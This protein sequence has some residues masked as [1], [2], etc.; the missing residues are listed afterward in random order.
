MSVEKLKEVIESRLQ[1][2]LDLQTEYKE[3]CRSDGKQIFVEIFKTFFDANPQADSI[4]WQ[5]YTPSFNDG[6]PCRFG[7]S[8][9]YVSLKED[10]SAEW[11]RE[12]L[13]EGDI[14]NIEY[15][16]RP[17]TPEER[18]ESP[19]KSHYYE[20]VDLGDRTDEQLLELQRSGGEREDGFF[21]SFRS[22][23]ELGKQWNEVFGAIRSSDDIMELTFG[24]GVEVTATREGIEVNEYYHD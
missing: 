18:K 1:K 14:E 23:S 5:Q 20:R 12:N 9:A 13:S 7:V 11:L 16:D 22:N 24:D 6:D 8:E 15:K 21:G 3:R 10:I 2:I 4:R 17:P 19:W